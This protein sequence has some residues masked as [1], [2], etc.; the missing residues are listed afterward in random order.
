[1]N[2]FV[3]SRNPVKIAAVKEAFSRYHGN[4]KVRG[5][6]VKSKVS[7]QPINDETFEGATNR[8]LSIKK[9]GQEKDLKAQFFVGIEG[10]I[11]QI[12]TRWFS[13]GAIC[14]IDEEGRIGY[15]TTPHFELPESISKEL[16]KR[17]ELGHVIDKIT[18]EHN[19]KQKEGAIGF[20]TKGR[21]NRK[22]LY[23]QGIIVSLVHFMNE[24][25]YFESL[26]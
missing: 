14:I 6:K 24:N 21:M 15:G 19:T 17:I 25:L 9:I 1:M 4:V 7:N 22:E 5:F 16:L 2:V 23:V 12:Y 11:R 13:F 3:G 26:L 8:A 20:L 10:G 18:G